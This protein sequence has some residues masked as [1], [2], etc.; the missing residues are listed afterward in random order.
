MK[1]PSANIQA[2]EKLQVANF[3]SARNI[4]ILVIGYSLELGTSILELLTEL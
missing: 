2:P 1:A 3:K 4:W